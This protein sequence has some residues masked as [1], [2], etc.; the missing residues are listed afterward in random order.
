MER[1]KKWRT[2][3]LVVGLLGATAL[4]PAAVPALLDALLLGVVRAEP[5]E[6]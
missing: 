5:S 2:A 4:A 6:S 1:I 3:I